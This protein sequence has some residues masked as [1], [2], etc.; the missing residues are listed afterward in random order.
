MV[1]NM[2]N[3]V[4]RLYQCMALLNVVVNNLQSSMY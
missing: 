1:D 2:S 4:I 3:R